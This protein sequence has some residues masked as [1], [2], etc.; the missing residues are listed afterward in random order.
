MVIV[1]VIMIDAADDA[2]DGVASARGGSPWLG[3]LVPSQPEPAKT[4]T[5]REA[6]ADGR[7][8]RAALS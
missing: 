7:E 6:R 5:P 8:A 3:Q 2:D 1:T 4:M